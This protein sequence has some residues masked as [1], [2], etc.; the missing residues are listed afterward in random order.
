VTWNNNSVARRGDSDRTAERRI[1]LT[2]P[3]PVRIDISVAWL[4]ER[5][6]DS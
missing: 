4:L 1:D 6:L 3:Q 2:R 5:T